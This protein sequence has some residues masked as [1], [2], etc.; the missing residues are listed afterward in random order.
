M[1]ALEIVLAA[2]VIGGGWYAHVR[3][4]P[5][6]GCPRCG[7]RERIKSGYAHRDCRKCRSTGRVR[8]FGAPKDSS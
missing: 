2:A 5:W 6:K 3:L 8:R 7:G 1:D 4:F